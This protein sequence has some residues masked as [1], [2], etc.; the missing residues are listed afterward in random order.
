MPEQRL[1]SWIDW[2]RFAR[3]KLDYSHTE[4]VVYANVRAVEEANRETLRQRQAA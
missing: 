1:T 4:A 3:G 2:Y